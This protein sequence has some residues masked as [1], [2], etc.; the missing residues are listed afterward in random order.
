MIDKIMV[1]PGA[2]CIE[3]CG[4]LVEGGITPSIGLLRR[5]RAAVSIPITVMI[6]PRGG[7]FLFSD[8][9]WLVN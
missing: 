9:G 1:I 6:R 4:S 8:M 7:D 2:T 3:V 5:I